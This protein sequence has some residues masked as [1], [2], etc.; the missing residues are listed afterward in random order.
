MTGGHVRCVRF[1]SAQEGLMNVDHQTDEGE[2]YKE[3]IKPLRTELPVF[4]E[5]LGILKNSQLCKWPLQ[6]EF[7]VFWEFLGIPRNS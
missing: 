2:M 5:F 1:F 6:N 7:P 4:W 3:T